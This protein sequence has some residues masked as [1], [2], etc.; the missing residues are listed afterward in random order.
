MMFRCEKNE[1]WRGGNERAAP[2]SLLR[3]VVYLRFTDGFLA[4][5]AA[6]KMVLFWR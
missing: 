5:V 3:F 2:P 4:A 1:W 6:V